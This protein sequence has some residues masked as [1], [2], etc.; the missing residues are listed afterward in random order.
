MQQISKMN[1]VYKTIFNIR[2]VIIKYVNNL[3]AK[4]ILIIYDTIQYIKLHFEIH[5]VDKVS[6]KN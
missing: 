1:K 5:N 6:V 3:A 4:L 2:I